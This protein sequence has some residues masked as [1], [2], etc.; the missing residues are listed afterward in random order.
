[1]AHFKAQ[2]MPYRKT[3]T[4]W[5]ILGD[6]AQRLHRKEDAKEA[7]QRALDTKF[8]PRAWLELLSIYVDERDVPRALNAATRLC[9]YNQ[10][11][12]HES[13]VGQSKAES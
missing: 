6:L 7:Y 4:E 2:H 8:S 12:Y 11:W 9:A 10:R 1:M 13:S 5:E 3:A